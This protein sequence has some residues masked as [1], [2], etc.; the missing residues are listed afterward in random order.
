MDMVDSFHSHTEI[1]PLS[2]SI[3]SESWSF[4]MDP[5]LCLSF[6]MIL[7]IFEMKNWDSNLIYK[8]NAE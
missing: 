2:F 4:S 1:Q 3:F 7:L 5:P 6:Q 8:A